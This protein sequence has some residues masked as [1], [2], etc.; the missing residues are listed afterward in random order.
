MQRWD[1]YTLR[2]EGGNFC[3]VAIYATPQLSVVVRR[4]ENS[5]VTKIKTIFAKKNNE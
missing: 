1:V 4:H 5:C 2:T 3:F